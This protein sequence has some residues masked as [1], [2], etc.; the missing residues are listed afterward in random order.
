MNAQAQLSRL[1]SYCL[2]ILS[3]LKPPIG[4]LKLNVDGTRSNQSGFIG[5]GGV[6]RDHNGDWLSG[7]SINLGV[8]QIIN[9]EARGMLSG[10]KLAS[11]LNIRKLEVESDSAIF[12]KLL[13]DGCPISH[14]L[15]NIINSCRHLINGFED[16]RIRHIFRECNYTAD[17]LAKGSLSHDYGIVIFDTPPPH[18][19]SD[20]P[21]HSNDS[22]SN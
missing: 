5:A 2:N 20:K 8:G 7:F 10:L 4:F 9:A 6:I 22:N 19:A 13:I 18:V 3:W 15:G 17:A 1:D 12:V 11:D 21:Y 16:V 14:P